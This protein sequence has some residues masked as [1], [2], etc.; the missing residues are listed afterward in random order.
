V[1]AETGNVKAGA[2]PKAHAGC[3]SSG[4]PLTPD[5]RFPKNPVTNDASLSPEAVNEVV[6][7][8]LLAIRDCYASEWRQ[9]PTLGGSVVVAWTIEPAGVVSQ[10]WIVERT[11]PSQAT[12]DCIGEEVCGWSFPPAPVATRIGRYPF[13]FQPR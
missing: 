13:V 7:G 10:A 9:N 6:H 4:P 11:L 5:P 8:H 2:Q 1:V 12:I 3:Y